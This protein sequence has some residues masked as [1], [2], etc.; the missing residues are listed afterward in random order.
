MIIIF[1]FPVLLQVGMELVKVDL[2]FIVQF[3]L[4]ELTDAHLHNGATQAALPC[5]H[6]DLLL[7]NLFPCLATVPVGR[8][9]RL[10]EAKTRAVSQQHNE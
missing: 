9:L 1:P 3:R 7:L 10:D 5:G 4:E 8:V 2:D 6:L